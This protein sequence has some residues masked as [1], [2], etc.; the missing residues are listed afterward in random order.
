FQVV[1]KESVVGSR[2]AFTGEFLD[3]RKFADRCCKMKLRTGKAQTHQFLSR[4]SDL[5]IK[6]Q[7]PT[8]QSS[9]KSSFGYVDRYVS[10]SQVKK[11]DT[12]FR[13][14]EYQLFGISALPI[15]SFNEGFT[16]CIGQ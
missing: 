16:S 10:S 15:A 8:R 6:E 12:V 3:R 9:I 13:V 2:D 7:I 5:G 14:D 1:G 4:L 11:F